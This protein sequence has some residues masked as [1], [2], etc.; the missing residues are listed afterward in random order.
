[1]NAPR[2]ISRGVHHEG[3]IQAVSRKGGTEPHHDF[4]HHR[5]WTPQRR[6]RWRIGIRGRTEIRTESR[7]RLWG[8]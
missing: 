5:L 2:I 6:W 7:E 3:I 4:A 1:M 8:E